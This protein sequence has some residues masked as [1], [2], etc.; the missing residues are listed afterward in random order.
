MKYNRIYKPKKFDNFTIIPSYILR[1]KGISIG[2]TGLYAW[3]FSHTS[4]QQITVEFICGHFKENQSAIRSKLNE[5]ISYGYLVRKRVYND[6]KIVGI[7]YYLHDNPKKLEVEN[8]NVENLNVENQAQ[9]NIINNNIYN[10]SNISQNANIEK[11]FEHFVNL[12]DL[13]YRPKTKTQIKNWMQCLD[14]CVRIDKY[15]LKELYLVCK[16]M[17]NNDFWKHNFLTL[18]KLRNHDK[19]GIFYI[20]RFFEIYKKQNK[21]SCYWKIK[22][23][24]QYLIYN[25]HDGTEKLGA[26][27]KTNKLNEFNLLQFLNKDEIQTLKNFV[28][29]H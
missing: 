26:I 19:N 4:K 17:R 3:L 15:D 20:D 8:L 5:L 24:K 18:L 7:D 11:S 9:S 1:H 10:K 12:F 29:G 2:A 25:D 16:Y 27:T 28:N 21:P 14:R 23:I 13:K 22:G 6:G